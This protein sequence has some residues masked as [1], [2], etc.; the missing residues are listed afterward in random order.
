MKRCQRLVITLSI[1]NVVATPTK[2][3]ANSAVAIEEESAFAHPGGILKLVDLVRD[4]SSSWPLPLPL[5]VVC[6]RPSIDA[7][8]C[9]LYI[10][11]SYSCTFP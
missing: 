9:F 5:D 7:L 3:S 6:S 2:R 4:E 10:L 1:T 11:S 8:V